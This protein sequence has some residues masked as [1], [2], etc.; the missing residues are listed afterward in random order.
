MIGLKAVLKTDAMSRRL[1]SH[2]V[3]FMRRYSN[4]SFSQI[5]IVGRTGA[6]KS[7]LLSMLFR[8]GHVSGTVRIDG[9][10]ISDL[11]LKDLRKTLSI[12]PQVSKIKIGILL[13]LYCLSTL[14]VILNRNF[15]I[16]NM[17]K[18][19]I[20]GTYHFWH[21]HFFFCNFNLDNLS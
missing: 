12:I 7:S 11:K 19:P 5:G 4:N 16:S 10:P 21:H 14:N 1:Q 8:M 13:I 9:Y 2:L 17:L 18:V 3:T 6:G 20:C 15:K